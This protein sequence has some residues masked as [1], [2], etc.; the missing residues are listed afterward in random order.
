MVKLAIRGL[1]SATRRQARKQGVSYRFLFIRPNGA[2]LREIAKLVDAGA[3]RPVVDRVMPF[4]QTPAA[5]DALLSG[6][7]RGKVLVSV[8]PRHVT[9][10][11][12]DHS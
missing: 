7:A 1:S 4:E 9:D 11:S 10:G 3:I 2:H 12:S 8:D 5:F 6:G